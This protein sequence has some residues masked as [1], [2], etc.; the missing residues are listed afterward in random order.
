MKQAELF[1]ELAKKFGEDVPEK[2]AKKIGLSGI[3]LRN[4]KNSQRELKPFQVASL[5]EKTQKHAI[6][7]YLTTLILPIVEFF[8]IEKDESRSGV[9]WEL[10]KTGKEKDSAYAELRSE[11]ES[12]SGIYVFYDSRGHVL[13]VGK[14][15]TN[16]LWSEM[17]HAFNRDRKDLQQVRLVKHPTTRGRFLPAY[18]KLRRIRPTQLVLADMAA[19]FSAYAIDPKFIASI[20]ALLVRVAANDLLNK[21]M[22]K[23]PYL[24]E[25]D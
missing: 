22:E 4:W 17:K 15:E 21:R 24:K 11:L 14:T 8:P 19:Y 1:D 3:G 12:K 10:F 6:D 7:K 23:F 18:K 20:E 5:I 13:Y 25:E 9:N 2:L 16:T